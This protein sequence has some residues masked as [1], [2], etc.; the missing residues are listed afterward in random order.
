MKYNEMIQAF[1]AQGI[2][3]NKKGREYGLIPDRPGEGYSFNI[4]KGI[5]K[6]IRIGDRDNGKVDKEFSCEEDMVEHMVS[7]IYFHAATYT[8]KQDETNEKILAVAKSLMKQH[9][10]D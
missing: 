3:I 10:K 8:F 7:R 5:F 1:K 4:E 9:E 2:D 6:H